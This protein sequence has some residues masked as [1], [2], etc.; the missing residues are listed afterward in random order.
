MFLVF[1]RLKN[2]YSK[3]NIFYAVLRIFLEFYDVE[4]LKSVMQRYG[5]PKKFV[6]ELKK[7]EKRI[8]PV[9]EMIK[10]RIKF[11]DIYKILGKPVFE[12]AAHILAYLDDEDSKN[13]FFEYL[14]RVFTV[15]L[16]L[17][18]NVLKE[19]FKIKSSPEIGKIMGEIFCMKL[20][21]PYINE[22]EKLKE[23]LGGRNG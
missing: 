2:I 12:T 20:D 9:I 1:K 15:K 21:N 10:M 19:K 5:L 13:Y 11:S 17:S 16:N 8:I 23:I 14:E 22:M 4:T 3:N 6:E 18:G 7:M